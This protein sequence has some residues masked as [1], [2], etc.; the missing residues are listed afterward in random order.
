MKKSA[1]IAILFV[2]LSTIST[3]LFA[4]DQIISAKIGSVMEKL[5]KNGTPFSVVIIEETRNLN[6]VEYQA[7]VVATAFRSAHE[8]AKQLK[9]GDT[10]KL[11]AN[12]RQYNGDKSYTIRKIIK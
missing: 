1:A 6:G 10:V 4:A 7:E 12:E 11:I 3:N 5:D 9:S 2:F 8:E